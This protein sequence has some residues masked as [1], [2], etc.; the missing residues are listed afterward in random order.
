[1]IVTPA[2]ATPVDGRNTTGVRG[3]RDCVL[4]LCHRARLGNRSAALSDSARLLTVPL[5]DRQADQG[6][7]KT[8]G[9]NARV[10]QS[11]ARIWLCV[12]P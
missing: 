12:Q 3:G 4:N 11:S 6:D 10:A 1:M 5:L 8:G 2:M 9:I 7:R